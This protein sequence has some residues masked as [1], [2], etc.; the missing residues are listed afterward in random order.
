MIF[1]IELQRLPDGRVKAATCT[2]TDGLWAIRPTVAE[3]VLA[4]APGDTDIQLPESTLGL[5]D[6]ET[7]EHTR[8]PRVALDGDNDAMRR[9][10][11]SAALE[12]RDVRL[13]YTDGDGNKSQR[14]V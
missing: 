8:T 2:E 10:L 3:A 7:T 1:S 11:T 13:D 14:V 9:L 5:G 4:V 12:D 6:P